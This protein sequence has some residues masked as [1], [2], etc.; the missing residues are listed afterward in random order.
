MT[1]GTGEGIGGLLF[2]AR[3]P[4]PLTA[5]YRERLGIGAG[6]TADE[7]VAPDEVWTVSVGPLAFSPFAADTDDS[8]PRSSTC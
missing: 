5:W 4:D 7:S 3:D 1:R 8:P 2:R 6:L